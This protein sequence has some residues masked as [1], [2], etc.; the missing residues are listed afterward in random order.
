VESPEYQSQSEIFLANEADSWYL[1]NRDHFESGNNSEI[2]VDFLC[3][4]L[5]PFRASIANILEIGCS[6]G[7][8]ITNLTEFFNA[9]G[10]GVDPSDMA[11]NTAKESA[12]NQPLELNFEVGLATDLPYPDQMFDLVYF[13]FCLY[14]IPPS[15]IYKA[16]MEA[17]RV[18]KQGGFIAIL[19]FD[20]G[21][22]RVNPYRHAEGVFSYKNNYSQIFTS[23]SYY[24][25]VNKWSFSHQGDYFTADREER[26][27]IEILYRELL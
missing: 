11:I 18:V 5:S 3:N 17:D 1:R 19:D 21:S 14:L 6:S 7:K 22:L 23:S 9:R 26:I 25:L 4:S 20:Y 16:L 10:F 8:K 24:S 13:G 2:D 27:S 15:E 12:Q